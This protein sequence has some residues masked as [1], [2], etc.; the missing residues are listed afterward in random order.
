MTA[1][2]R[3]HVGHLVRMAQQIHTRVWT[4]QVSTEISSPQSQLLATL[5]VHPNIDQSTATQLAGLDR[6]TGAVLMERLSRFGYVE[7]VRDDI[8]KRRYLLRLTPKGLKLRR[9]LQPLTWALHDKMLSLIS[10]ELREP[11]LAAL[12][13]MVENDAL[14]EKES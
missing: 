8:D 2:P 7:R 14:A 12:E 9:E 13:M 3:R 5:D 10:E 1:P 11:F 4:S 6:S